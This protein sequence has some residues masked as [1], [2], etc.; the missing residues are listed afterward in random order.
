MSTPKNVMCKKDIRKNFFSQR[1]INAW[2][3]LSQFVVDAVTVNAFKNRLDK[4]DRFF[5]EGN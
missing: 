2:N 3:G 4:F 5:M 1:V